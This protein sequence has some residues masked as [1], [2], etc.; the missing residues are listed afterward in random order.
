MPEAVVKF[1]EPIFV[2]LVSPDLLQKCLHGKTQNTNECLNKLIWDRCSKE[3]YVEKDTVEEAVYSAVSYFNDGTSSV[4]KMFHHL[5]FDGWY[6]ADSSKRKDLF[7]IANSTVK[8]AESTQKR[9]KTLRAIKKGFQDK[10]EANEG[11][12]YTPG[13]H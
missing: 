5:G 2:D 7:R 8:S 1:I 3:Y 4:V 11:D 9:R 13:G 10:T 6:T 12:M